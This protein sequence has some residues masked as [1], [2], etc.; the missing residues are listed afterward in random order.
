MIPTSKD[1]SE[2]TEIMFEEYGFDAL[3][4][5]K[6]SD[7]GNTQSVIAMPVILYS[8][9]MKSMEQGFLNKM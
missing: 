2:P 6:T 5:L 8:E 3:T 9:F 7:G 4:A 1:G